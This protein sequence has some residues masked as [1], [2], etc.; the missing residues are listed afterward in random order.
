[1]PENVSELRLTIKNIDNFEA[2]QSQVVSIEVDRLNIHI[3]KVR[4]IVLLK[5]VELGISHRLWLR[6]F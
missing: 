5:I 2:A 3:F 6:K 4:K 1:L